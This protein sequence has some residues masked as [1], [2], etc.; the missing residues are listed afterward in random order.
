MN[1]KKN[2]PAEQT[3]TATIYVNN[4][5]VTGVNNGTAHAGGSTSYEYNNTYAY[6]TA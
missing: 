3:V 1:G 6:I 4:G 5:V 2:V